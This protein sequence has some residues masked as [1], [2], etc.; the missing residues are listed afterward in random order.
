ML[1]TWDGNIKITEVKRLFDFSGTGISPWLLSKSRN[2]LRPK[3]EVNNQ[4]INNSV[5]S[6]EEHFA[7]E[8]RKC[9]YTSLD[10][11]LGQVRTKLWGKEM[12]FQTTPKS[13]PMITLRICV[14]GTK[15]LV[16]P[17]QQ[18]VKIGGRNRNL[19]NNKHIQRISHNTCWCALIF[20]DSELSLTEAQDN[21]ISKK[22]N[23]FLCTI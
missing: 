10:W 13:K 2:H 21:W 17:V 22:I 23:L 19:S 4:H 7:K 12:T 3:K 20:R 16:K 11:L 6:E 15:K 9:R 8:T 14:K 5:W 1:R 18:C